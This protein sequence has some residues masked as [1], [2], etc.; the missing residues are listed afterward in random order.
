MNDHQLHQIMNESLIQLVARP[1]DIELMLSVLSHLYKKHPTLR[2]EFWQ[3]WYR[4]APDLMDMSGA[5]RSPHPVV[6]LVVSLTN[7]LPLYDSSFFV[8]AGCLVGESRSTEGIFFLFCRPVVPLTARP[9]RELRLVRSADASQN[10]ISHGS[11]VESA[12]V[13]MRRSSSSLFVSTPWQTDRG[14]VLGLG[15]NVACVRWSTPMNVWA[16]VFATIRD[17]CHCISRG[18]AG[19]STDALQMAGLSAVKLLAALFASNRTTAT[20]MFT[21]L[22]KESASRAI[23]QCADVLDDRVAQIIEELVRSSLIPVQVED[24]VRA[25]RQQGYVVQTEV[26][27]Y[28]VGMVEQSDAEV[29]NIPLELLSGLLQALI[30]TLPQ[31]S[32][33]TS[34]ATAKGSRGGNDA[35]YLSADFLPQFTSSCLVLFSSLMTCRHPWSSAAIQALLSHEGNFG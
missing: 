30:T 32:A 1:D 15:N 5:Y 2:A 8:L 29:S 20:E 18:G 21:F 24:V 11:I 25:V 14:I 7:C 12:S 28:V 33:R 4:S 13:D 16:Y 34:R 6:R 26:L 10:S 17:T 22:S 19:D 31:L 9:S 35:S 23:K 27:E 3:E